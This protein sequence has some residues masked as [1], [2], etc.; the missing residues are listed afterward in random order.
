MLQLTSPS[1]FVFIVIVIVVVVIIFVVVVLVV[2]VIFALCILLVH[3]LLCAIFCLRQQHQ[4]PLSPLFQQLTDHRS[5]ALLIPT[6]LP[7][8]QIQPAIFVHLLYLC[9]ELQLTI[10]HPRLLPDSLLPLLSHLP[11][12][13]FILCLILPLCLFTNHIPLFCMYVCMYLILTPTLC[14]YAR[15]HQGLVQLYCIRVSFLFTSQLI[16]VLL[17]LIIAV[18]LGIVWLVPPPS[19]QRFANRT[20]SIHSG[21]QRTSRGPYSP[22]PITTLI[23]IVLLLIQG[24]VIP[25]RFD[26]FKTS[27]ACTPGGVQ[28]RV[29]D[30]DQSLPRR[31]YILRIVRPQNCSSV[32]CCKNCFLSPWRDKGL[33]PLVILIIPTI[34]TLLLELEHLSNLLVVIVRNHHRGPRHVILVQRPTRPYPHALYEELEELDA[35]SVLDSQVGHYGLLGVEVVGAAD[36]ECPI[37][38]EDSPHFRK[39]ALRMC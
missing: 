39:E 12:V 1:P 33:H 7:R 22:H 29:R 24:R 10:E 37:G 35:I 13:L 19:K 38:L 17:P 4:P 15:L 34:A 20:P 11:L 6:F 14:Y 3:M 25:S 9:L 28:P 31:I 26:L 5:L 23:H 30:A 16:I 21:I 18:K 32:C 27:M 8:L 2:I 36:N